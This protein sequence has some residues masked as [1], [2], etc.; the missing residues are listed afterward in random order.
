LGRYLGAARALLTFEQQ[1]MFDRKA[2]AWQ[3]RWEREGY[4][5]E[6]F[7]VHP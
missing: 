1:A 4:R 5:V 2:R 6:I 7:G 3:E